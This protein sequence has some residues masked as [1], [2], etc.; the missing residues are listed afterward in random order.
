M[1][2]AEF[3][4]PLG[5]GRYSSQKRLRGESV[6]LLSWGNHGAVK[7]AE[8]DTE[9]SKDV[10]EVKVKGDDGNKW[11]LYYDAKIGD[12]VKSESES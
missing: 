7:E 11:E 4:T 12:L 2:R 8:M 6:T 10:W 3:A 1:W 5:K 9:N